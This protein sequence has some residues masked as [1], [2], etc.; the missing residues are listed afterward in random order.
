MTNY[1]LARRLDRRI[2]V[3]LCLV[4]FLWERL[5]GWLTGRRTV[6]SF[7][8]T[9]PPRAAPIPAPRRVLGIKFYGL[10][11]TVMLVPVLAAV[12]E[13]FP[14]AEVDFLTLR[15]NASLLERSGVADRVIGVDTSSLGRFAR[16]MWHAVRAIRRRRY[17]VVLDF[18]QFIKLSSL[19][20][21]VS[22]TPERIGFNTDGQRRG[23]MY[24]T[25]VVY[26]DSDHMSGIYARLLRPL[27]IVGPLPPTLLRTND[28]DR[29]AVH[30]FLAEIGI[31]PDRFPLVAIHMGIGDN[32][33]RI[34]LKRWDPKHFAT[35]ANGL[36]ARWGAAIVFT[37]RGSEEHALIG[38]AR[39]HMTQPSFDACDRFSVPELA[40]LLERCHFVVAN[41]TSV[42]HLAGLVGTPVVAIFGPTAPLHYGPRGARNLVFYRDLYCSPCLTNYNLKVS[43]CLDPVCMRG[44]H[45]D[46]VLAGIAEHYLGDAAEHRDWLRARAPASA[47]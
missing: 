45:P 19:F 28:A 27:G 18:E 12:R 16:T 22:G 17:D 31:A 15:G 33:Y 3:V 37:G 5:T 39:A 6:P 14:D 20:A 25:R 23:F 1:N 42:M 8:A 38:A 24:T 9:T 41:D 34:P 30:D 44:I 32:V 47:A 29:R 36:A 46:E 11:N 13:R 35:V 21:W 26:T 10:G 43:R 4:L 7:L 40:A 2:G